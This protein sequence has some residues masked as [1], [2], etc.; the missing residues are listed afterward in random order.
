MNRIG[1][2][3]LECAGRAQ[4]RRR[5]GSRWRRVS[6]QDMSSKGSSILH[7]QKAVW[8]FASRRSPQRWRVHDRPC[9]K[10]GVS[11]ILEGAARAQQPRGFRDGARRLKPCESG[12]ALRLQPTQRH[13]GYESV[14]GKA[15]PPTL[16]AH[17]RYQPV[18]LRTPVFQPATIVWTF[19]GHALV[20]PDDASKSFL[21][22]GGSR[23]AH[24]FKGGMVEQQSKSRR[25]G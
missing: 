12:V 3:L 16:D 13:L 6:P 20:E 17:P 15:Q 24:P 5:F 18:Q 4:R 9:C 22:E 21:P 23:I 1:R 19:F 14:H 11:D 2:H 25:D 7:I 10:N 8:R